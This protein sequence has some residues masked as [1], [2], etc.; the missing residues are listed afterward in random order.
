MR[1]REKE[2]PMG[3]SELLSSHFVNI[4]KPLSIIKNN[5]KIAVEFSDGAGEG[6]AYGNLVIAYKSL[7]DFGKSNEYHQEGLKNCIRK[8]VIGPEKEKPNK[9]SH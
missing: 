3:I 1:G 7:V 9:T 2:E 4:G 5:W 6:R 8:S